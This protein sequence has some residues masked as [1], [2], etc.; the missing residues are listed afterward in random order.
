MKLTIEEIKDCIPHRYPFLFLDEVLDF[1]SGK[2]LKACRKF[3]AEEFFFKGHFPDYPVVPGVIIVE[4]MAQAGGV[5]VNKSDSAAAH[6][7]P[8]A[9]VGLDRVK[10]R[11]PVR[12]GDEVFF[13]IELIRSR[14]RL[15][16][17][18]GVA[19]VEGKKVAEAEITATVF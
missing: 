5:L 2:R 9:L 14:P 1:E 6:K 17:L 3:L 4:A 18:H 15:W 12:P 13:E 11:R 7:N 10:F 19:S 8:P 16:K